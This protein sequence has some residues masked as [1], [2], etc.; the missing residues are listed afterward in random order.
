MRLK[1]RP[2]ITFMSMFFHGQ[3]KNITVN[4]VKILPKFI[5]KTVRFWKI[6]VIPVLQILED[7]GRYW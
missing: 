2:L 5:V 4:F 1:G 6:L 7:S 3:H